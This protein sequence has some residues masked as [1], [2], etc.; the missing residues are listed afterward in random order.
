MKSPTQVTPKG[1]HL[2]KAMT[3][4]RTASGSIAIGFLLLLSACGSDGEA[5][6]TTSV[7]AATTSTAAKDTTTTGADAAGDGA[8]LAQNAF[9]LAAETS[10]AD[11]RVAVDEAFVEG[12]E[13]TVQPQVAVEVIADHLNQLYDQI[14]AVEADESEM[15]GPI[16]TYLAAVLAAGEEADEAQGSVDTAKAYLSANSEKLTAVNEAGAVLGIDDCAVRFAED[17]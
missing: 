17:A 14:S 12:G 5:A 3:T 7:D 9:I 15:S 6:A 1:E 4:R 16:E 2:M 11:T 13:S 8:D 10:C